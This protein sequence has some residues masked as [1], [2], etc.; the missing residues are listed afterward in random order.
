MPY[1]EPTLHRLVESQQAI[2]WNQIL[3]GRWTTEWVRSYDLIYPNQG[4][5]YATAQLTSLWHAVLT[6]WK[7]RC[8][9]LHDTETNHPS[10]FKKTLEPKVQAL[11]AMKQE[12][13]HIDQ[14]A[15]RQT[16]ETT[17]NLPIT[18]IRGWIKQTDAF[19]RQAL[20]RRKKRLK[21]G[22]HAITSYFRPT[23]TQPHETQICQT[24]V[25][26]TQRIRTQPNTKDTLK[27]P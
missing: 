18:Q 6:T 1:F 26:Q 27:P 12:I 4:E 20:R 11:Y 25:T 24:P 8:E 19:I 9:L 22:T 10:L 14:Q 16:I 13:D 21:N 23:N 7:Q 3:K 17:M 5:K 15:L 2:G